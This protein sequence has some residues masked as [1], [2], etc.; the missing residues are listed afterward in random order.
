MATIATILSAGSEWDAKDAGDGL[1]V[2]FFDGNSEFFP[3]GPGSALGYSNFK[4]PLAY[5][6]DTLGSTGSAAA[7]NGVR[8]GYVGVGFDIRG[9]YSNTTDGKVGLVLSGYSTETGVDTVSSETISTLNPNSVS[10]R[11]SE[12][13]AYKLHSTS[14]NLSTFPLEGE[15][16]TQSTPVQLHQTVSTR[17]DVEFQ[18]ARV[19]LQNQGKRVLVELKDKVTGIYHQ[20]HVADLD[21]DGFAGSDNPDTVRVGIGFATSDAVTNCDIKNFSVYGTTVEQAKSNALLVPLSGES[22]NVVYPD[23]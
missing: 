2:F 23:A 9:N 22:F 14:Q 21:N 1:C 4:G 17:D 10:V 7:V 16:F 15:R 13:S 11:M 12:A 6:A 19:T 5:K 20:Y 18:S 3:G 8:G